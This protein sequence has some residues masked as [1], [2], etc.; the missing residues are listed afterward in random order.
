MSGDEAQAGRTLAGRGVVVTG[1]GRGIGRACALLAA[2]QGAHVVVSDLG[3]SPEGEGR[4]ASVVE[5]VAAEIRAA[6]GVALADASDLAEVGA[7]ERLIE[8]ARERLG[9]V[10]AVIAC[11]GILVDRPAMKT[12]PALLSRVLATHVAQVFALVRAAAPAMVERKDGAFVWLTGASAF[13]GARGHAAE[14]AAHGATLGAMRAMALELRK[15]NVR[16]NALVPSARTRLTEGQPL[17]QSIGK[18]SLS[19]EHVAA[20]AVFLASPEASDVTGE[21]VGV[22]GSRT[23][24]YKIRETPGAFGHPTELPSVAAAGALVRGA[25]RG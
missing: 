17:Y 21:I 14:A 20:T 8:L 19:A 12:E 6:G 22:A 1:G 24:A 2:A 13:F 15:H 16:V 18:T 23:Y 10:S 3:C 4:D 5:A 9:D 25:L 11:A 7:P